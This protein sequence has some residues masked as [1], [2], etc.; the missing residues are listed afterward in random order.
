MLRPTSS[1]LLYASTPTRLDTWW[2]CWESTC[3]ADRSENFTEIVLR[4]WV[5]LNMKALFPVTLW[6]SWRRSIVPSASSRELWAKRTSQRSLTE[7]LESRTGWVLSGRG[8]WY[9]HTNMTTRHFPPDCSETPYAVFA[10]IWN[11]KSNNQTF[12]LVIPNVDHSVPK[13]S[14]TL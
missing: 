5:L 3:T 2:V 14:C 4:F 8:G 11:I 9:V 13:T 10:S 6:A 12:S 7:W 1:S